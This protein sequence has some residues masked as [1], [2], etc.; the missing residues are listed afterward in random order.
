M[1]L[2]VS[3]DCVTIVCIAWMAHLMSRRENGSVHIIFVAFK[4]RQENGWI[5]WDQ[6]I[7]EDK[8]EVRAF[9]LKLSRIEE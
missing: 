3:W 8:A 2:L 7:F 9:L 4:T 6:V 1:R 5:A